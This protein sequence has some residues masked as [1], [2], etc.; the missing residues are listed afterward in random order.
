MRR[1]A[2]A[3]YTY[4]QISAVM[5]F[6]DGVIALPEEIEARVEAQLRQQIFGIPIRGQ[7]MKT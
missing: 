6:L 1:L 5:T 7:Q 4:E 2:R 3:G